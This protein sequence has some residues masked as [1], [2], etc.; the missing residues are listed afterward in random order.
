MS[1]KFNA[2]SAL[3]TGYVS[4]KFNALREQSRMTGHR[5]IPDFRMEGY[6]FPRTGHLVPAGA[7]R[8]RRA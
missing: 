8:Q 4:M 5:A 1:T 6:A 3:R 7:A 2:Y